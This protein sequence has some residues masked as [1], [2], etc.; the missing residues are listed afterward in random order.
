VLHACTVALLHATAGVSL[1]RVTV[2]ETCCPT[3]RLTAWLLALPPS[4][5]SVWEMWQLDGKIRGLE[6]STGGKAYRYSDICHRSQAGGCLQD[7]W[8]PAGRRDTMPHPP[9]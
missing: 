1:S 4:P 5:Q 9:L 6:V 8:A 7:G 3:D 2:W